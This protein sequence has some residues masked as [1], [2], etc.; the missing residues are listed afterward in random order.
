MNQYA[1]NFITEVFFFRYIF[2]G[3]AAQKMTKWNL[4]PT[5]DIDTESDDAY[6]LL[7]TTVGELETKHRRPFGRNTVKIATNITIISWNAS[8]IVDHAR[9]FGNTQIEEFYWPKWD[10]N[11][12]VCELK[13]LKTFSLLKIDWRIKDGHIISSIWIQRK[14]D[15]ARNNY[16]VAVDM[17]EDKELFGKIEYFIAQ[18]K[19]NDD[20]KKAKKIK[21]DNVELAAT[22]TNKLNTNVQITERFGDLGIKVEYFN[23]EKLPENPPARDNL[24]FKHSEDYRNRLIEYLSSIN[25]KNEFSTFKG[26]LSVLLLGSGTTIIDEADVTIMILD[27]WMQFTSTI[28][29]CQNFEIWLEI[30][31]SNE[32]ISYKEVE[33]KYKQFKTTLANERVMCI[34]QVCDNNGVEFQQPSEKDFNFD[35]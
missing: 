1:R 31:L 20:A 6:L 23:S 10:Y 14:A 13:Q 26:A 4:S 2:V 12:T 24:I 11:L 7:A 15:I 29:G 33:I 21:K 8:R 5:L 16:Y 28:N 30:I 32:V 25:H 3:T 17:Y 19:N 22:V 34:K 35:Y 9:A 27:F 18:K